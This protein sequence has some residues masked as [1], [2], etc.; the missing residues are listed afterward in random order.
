MMKFTIRIRGPYPPALMESGDITYAV[1]GNRW[2][3]ILQDI[4]DRK[5]V[6]DW[7]KSFTVPVK[8][9][10]AE[11]TKEYKSATSD[12]VYTVKSR[13]NG[14]ISCTCPGFMYHRKCRHIDDFKKRVK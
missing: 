6:I 4:S 11:K 9:S 1:S 7:T 3:P 10:L 5:V 13:S 14:S 2:I 8:E 12:K